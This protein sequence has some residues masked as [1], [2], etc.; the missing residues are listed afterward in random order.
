M[1]ALEALSLCLPACRG[2]NS[3][4]FCPPYS[5]AVIEL[6]RDLLPSKVKAVRLISH[7]CPV[8][9]SLIHVIYIAARL[10]HESGFHLVRRSHS[11]L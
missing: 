11:P 3:H 5:P 7:L 6:A 10:D 4:T 8:V 1:F 9:S 2:P